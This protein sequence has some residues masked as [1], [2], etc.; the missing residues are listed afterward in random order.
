MKNSTIN[1]STQLTHLGKRGTRKLGAA[2][3]LRPSWSP[4]VAAI[5]EALFCPVA[6][7]GQCNRD[8]TPE[9]GLV[10]IERFLGR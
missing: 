2:R 10:E 1:A 5:A 9:S 7:F 6:A 3:R 8:E 4:L